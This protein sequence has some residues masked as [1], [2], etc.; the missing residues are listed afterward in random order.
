MLTQKPLDQR[1]GHPILITGKGEGRKGH[2]IGETTDDAEK[3]SDEGDGNREV[4]SAIDWGMR[5]KWL[6]GHPGWR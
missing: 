2:D 5:I 1:S 6:I 4:K 3:R